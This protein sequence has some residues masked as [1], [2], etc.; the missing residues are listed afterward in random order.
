MSLHSPR[1]TCSRYAVLLA[2]FSA[3]FGPNDTLAAPG[4]EPL[5]LQQ[6][7][8]KALEQQLT[9]PTPD[10]RLSPPASSFSRIQFP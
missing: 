8:Q 6:Q 1:L 2:I 5:I 3:F 10:V 4:D 7:R 9:P